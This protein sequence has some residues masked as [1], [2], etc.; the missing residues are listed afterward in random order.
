M[1][2]LITLA[3]ATL[4]GTGMLVAQGAANSGQQKKASGKEK[5]SDSLNPQPEPPGAQQS[6]KKASK[7][8]A[9][10]HASGEVELN[11][12]PLP[13]HATENVN[14]SPAAKV[15]FNPQPDPPGSQAKNASKKGSPGEAISLNPQPEP[16]GRQKNVG[17]T[18][19]SN[20]ADKTALNPQ[21]LPPGAK[22]GGTTASQPQ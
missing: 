6:H 13:P 2:R 19:P 5:V 7:R 1:N 8:A 17:Q 4:L 3:I 12:Q 15:G 18:K 21:P 10:S 20:A 14:V 16:P 11:P 22:K 9:Q